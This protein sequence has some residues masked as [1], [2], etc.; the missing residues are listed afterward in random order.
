MM[1]SISIYTV[2]SFFFY[3]KILPILTQPELLYCSTLKTPT[4]SS[5]IALFISD[6]IPIFTF[7]LTY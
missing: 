2:Q 5:H 1:Y 4:S 6:N 3:L 7:S